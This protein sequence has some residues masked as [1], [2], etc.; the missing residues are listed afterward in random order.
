MVSRVY[1]E[2]KPGFDVEAQQLAHELRTILGV[3]ALAGLRLV[4]R[5]DVEGISDE[6]FEACVPT[7]VSYTH[8]D[9]YKRQMRVRAGEHLIDVVGGDIPRVEEAAA[10]EGRSAKEA[11][12]LDENHLGALLLCEVGG[13]ASACTATKDQDIGLLVEVRGCGGLFGKGGGGAEGDTGASQGSALEQCAARGGE[14]RFHGSSL[15]LLVRRVQAG[16][17]WLRR[18]LTS[19]S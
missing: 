4:N 18:R 6:L 1:V 2:K 19:A 9:V 17:A 15:G 7:A 16:D 13:E 14:V 11:R 10:Q 5:Y 3:E 12:G 8:L